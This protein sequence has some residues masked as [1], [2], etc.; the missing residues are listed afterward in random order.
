METNKKEEE[1]AATVVL[2]IVVERKRGLLDTNAAWCVP[3]SL[4]KIYL[5]FFCFYSFAASGEMSKLNCLH[6]DLRL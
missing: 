4:S 6:M 1:E 3:S 2:V 5:I